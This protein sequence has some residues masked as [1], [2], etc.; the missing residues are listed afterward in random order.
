MS[1]GRK[2]DFVPDKAIQEAYNSEFENI[3][4]FANKISELCKL[5]WIG[6]L[7]TY[8]AAL[9]TGRESPGAAF[10]SSGRYLLLAAAI[11]GTGAF[12]CEYIQNLCGYKHASQFTDWIENQM[13]GAN[14]IAYVEYNSRTDTAWAKMNGYFFLS[15][16]IFAFAS[17]VCILVAIVAFI[18]K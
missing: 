18:T 15:K 3:K 14:K 17:A 6:S 5:I 4:I 11:C 10:Y 7:A 13:E 12:V 16:N 8:F 2:A 1:K 9:T